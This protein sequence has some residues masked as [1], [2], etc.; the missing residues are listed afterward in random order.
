MIL[1][2]LL[3]QCWNFRHAPLAWQNV[4]LLVQVRSAKPFVPVDK[5]NI[6]SKI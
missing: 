3:L 5:K 1:V 6:G 2:P 4:I